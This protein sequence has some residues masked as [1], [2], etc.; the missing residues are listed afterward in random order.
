MFIFVVVV[1]GIAWVFSYTL[2]NQMI[3]VWALIGSL[4]MNFISYWYSDSIVL[5][6]SNAK[7]VDTSTSEGKRIYRLLENLA[8]T[9]GLPMPKL[10]II[11]DTAMNAFA[12]GRDPEHS[13]IALTTG[14]IDRL[15]QIE[16]EGVIAHELSHI[17]NRDTLIQTISVVLVGLVALL[18]DWFLRISFWGGGKH[19]NDDNSKLGLIVGIIAVVL[20]ILAP[21][22]VQLLHFAI[23]RKREYLA[24]ASGALLTRYPEGLA[25]ALEK[26]SQDTEPLEVANRATAH[27]FISNPFKGGGIK[28]W[29]ST[30]PP[31]EKRIQALR[32]IHIS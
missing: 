2:N 3:F 5:S 25:S 26:I 20:A 19:N 28:D 29:M 9:A 13:A 17:G 8:I 6:I 18:S 16:L 22:F 23:S 27:L 21:I 10:Y 1:V 7:P 14:I 32:N 4:F 12:T 30:H 15:E 31:T 11:Q 24:D